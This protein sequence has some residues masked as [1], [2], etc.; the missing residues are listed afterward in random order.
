MNDLSIPDW[1][2][3]FQDEIPIPCDNQRPFVCNGFRNPSE[4]DV[5]FIN[6]KPRI[7]LGV[8]WW[9]FW[10]ETLGW[11]YECFSV[12]CTKQSSGMPKDFRQVFPKHIEA[13]R[14]RCVEAGVYR[15]EDPS[16]SSIYDN[17]EV[18]QLLISNIPR[19]RGI[20]TCGV[21]AQQCSSALNI[22]CDVKILNIKERTDHTTITK[23]EE[24]C[25]AL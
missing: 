4:C 25:R 10:N 18:L 1:T 20:I 12:I 5:L 21:V 14:L 3:L 13:A 15:N 7:Q 9:N 22:C 19:L 11:E 24:F 6:K 17:R 8:D 16:V 23:L 2:K